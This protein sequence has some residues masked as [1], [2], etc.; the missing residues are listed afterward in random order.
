[1]TTRTA[2]ISGPISGLANGNADN[3]MRAQRK[4]EHER[5]IVIN[6][7]E[8]G[9][10]LYEKWSKTKRPDNEIQARDYDNTMWCEFMKHDIKYLVSC[11]CVFLLDNWETSRGCKLEILIAQKLNIPIY[12]MRD[13]S[14]F[15]ISFEIN[16]RGSIPV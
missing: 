11:D 5:Y 4:L 2:Y 1:M 6:P 13:Y 15:D 8:I 3:F 7:H 9:R 10:D 16:K 12:Y 14:R